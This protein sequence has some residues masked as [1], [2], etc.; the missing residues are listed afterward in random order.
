MVINQYN[1]YWTDLNPTIGSEVNKTRPCVVLSPN[2]MNHNINTIIV[3]PVTSTLK[4]YPTRILCN[5]GGKPGAIML[6]QIRTVD[7]QRVKGLLAQLT[8]ADIKRVK[9]VISQMLC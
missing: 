1:I 6:D 4:L 2:E 5:V 7:K 3:A 8:E 9:S